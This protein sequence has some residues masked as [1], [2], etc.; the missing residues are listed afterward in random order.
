M[1]CPFCE[2]AMIV[3]ELNE[4][5]IDHCVDCGGVWLD[6]NELELLLE[7]AEEKEEVIN[8][9]AACGDSKEKSLLCPICRKKM[10]KTFCGYDEKVLLDKCPTNDGLWFDAGEL[11]KVIEMGCPD[12]NNK[13]RSLLRDMFSMNKNGGKK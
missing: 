5:E 2:H 13:I 8:S 1:N 6:K 7:S 3:L 12:K 4:I 11:N 9:L 10:T